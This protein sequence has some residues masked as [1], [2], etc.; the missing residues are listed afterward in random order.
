MLVTIHKI[1]SLGDHLKSLIIL[2]WTIIEFNL[3]NLTFQI[4]TILGSEL[5]YE[6]IKVESKFHSIILIF[7][8][9][10]KLS[11]FNFKGNFPWI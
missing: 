6:A 7:P 4:K 10:I 5:L 1:F 9:P 8:I 2:L 3:H 11:K